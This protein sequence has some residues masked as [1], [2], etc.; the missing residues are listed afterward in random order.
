MLHRVCKLIEQ[1]AAE[2]LEVLASPSK[3]RYYD[4]I[5]VV[6]FCRERRI[7]RACTRSPPNASHPCLSGM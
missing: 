4:A 7:L 6:K 5:I 2:E 1:G 3:V